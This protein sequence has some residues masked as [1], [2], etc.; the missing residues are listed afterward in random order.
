MQYII[1]ILIIIGLAGADYVTGVIKAYCN[2]DICSSKM[3]KGG[4][5]KLGEIIVMATACGL[6]IGIKMLGQ[7]YNSDQLAAV[8]GK[9]TAIAVFVYITIMELVSILENYAEINTEAAWTKK[10][11]TRLKNVN[12]KEDK[13]A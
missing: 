2:N 8:T 3:R 9:I 10:I 12:N 4:L 1:M 13:N 7:Y 6:E 5:N 11:I